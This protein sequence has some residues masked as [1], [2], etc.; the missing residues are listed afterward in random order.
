MS[1][2]SRVDPEHVRVTLQ[3][4]EDLFG[5]GSSGM[6]GARLWDDRLWPDGTSRPVT[7]V[8]KH[9]GALRAMFA[10][11]GELALS[12]AYLYDDFDIEGSIE[13]VFD[14]VEQLAARTSG[15]SRKVSLFAALHRLPRPE[16]RRVARRGPARLRGRQHSE[17]RDGEAVRYHYDVSNDFYRLFLDERMVYS[18]A[19]FATAETGLDEAQVAKLDLICRKLRLS[20]GQRMLDVGCG[21]GGLVL[22]AARKYGV[23]ATGITLSAPQVELA[24]RRI[25]EAGMGKSCRVELTDYRQVSED[26]PFDALVSVGMFEHVGQNMLPGYFEKAARLL[27]HG[28]VFLNH[29][30]ASRATDRIS[31]GP[32]FSD[33]YV[34]PDGELVPINTTLRAAEEAGFEVR[35]VE[36]LREHYALTLRHWVRRLETRHAQALQ[37]VDEATYRVWRLYMSGSA[38]GFSS[39]RL[40]VYQALLAFPDSRG[41]SGLPLTRTDWYSLP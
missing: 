17:R 2:Q 9:P 30:I 36:S 38:H 1:T 10:G 27:K 37:H 6:I 18:C 16:H 39:R 35:D 3:L 15:W 7:L 25:A 29:G 11:G 4:L 32:S 24:N 31:R 21:W 5:N 12:E 28:G 8:L 26:R 22:H 33:S 34:F 13:S 41:A 40:N 14:I 20:P 19:Y 23:D